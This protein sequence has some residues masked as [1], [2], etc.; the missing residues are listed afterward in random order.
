[1]NKKVMIILI[2]LIAVLILFVGGCFFIQLDATKKAN[3]F[4][5]KLDKYYST[6]EVNETGLYLDFSKNKNPVT[7]AK[8][9]EGIVFYDVDKKFYVISNLKINNTYCFFKNEKFSCGLFNK[10][11][12][13]VSK[14]DKQDAYTVGT[15]VKLADNSSWHVIHKSSEYSGYVTLI[16]DYKLDINND[17]FLVDIGSTKDPDRIPFDENGIKKYD[18]NA[19]GN[20]GYYLENTFKPTLSTYGNV[21]EVRLP[22]LDELERLK[23]D[24]GFSTLTEEQRADMEAAQFEIHDLI[25]LYHDNTVPYF[26]PVE[27][28]EELKTRLNP[29]WLFNSYSGS[30]WVEYGKKIRSA[31]WDGDGYTVKKPTTGA[32]VKPVITVSKDMINS[33]Y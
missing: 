21:F 29:H 28:S 15:G 25:G 30:Y 8:I 18:T 10:K 31:G 26:E 23:E 1:M 6:L 32:S 2:I 19:K 33:T 16:R 5:D 17:N 12:Q 24:I 9:S 14:I 4:Y 11:D 3:D 27:I 7:K 20:V 22:N 13:E